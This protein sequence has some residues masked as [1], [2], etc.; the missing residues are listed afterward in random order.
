[1]SADKRKADRNRASG[2]LYCVVVPQPE[3][4]LTRNGKTIARWTFQ[5]SRSEFPAPTAVAY[6]GQG[7]R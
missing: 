2:A 6:A 1:M 7:G 3:K 4:R 5:E